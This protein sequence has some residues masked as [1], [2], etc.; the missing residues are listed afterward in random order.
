MRICLMIEG[1][2]GVS[3]DE[4]VALGRAAEE[5]R[6]EGLFRSDHY[7]GLMGDETRGSLDAWTQIA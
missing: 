1:Q 3:W 4:W 7:A 5:S 6:L 2:E